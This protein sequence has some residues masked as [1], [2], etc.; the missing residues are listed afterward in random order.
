MRYFFLLMIVVLFGCHQPE[1]KVI[2]KKTPVPTFKTSDSLSRIQKKYREESIADSLHLDSMLSAALLYAYKNKAR[3]NF[4]KNLPW[5]SDYDANAAILLNYGHLFSSYKKH[6][7]ITRHLWA[8]VTCI[9]VFEYENSKFVKINSQYKEG[10]DFVRYQIKDVNGD[11]QKDFLTHW[12]PTS[13]CCRR[14]VY[15]VFLYL[16]KRQAFTGQYEFINPTYSP[17]KKI[18]RGVNY[19]HPGEVPLYKYKWNGLNIDTIEYIYPADTLK[20]KFYLVHRHSEQNDSQKRKTLATVPKEYLK[21]D[22]YDWFID[23]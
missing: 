12:Y 10:W 7:I 15:D 13:G 3:P 11:G 1:K 9:D 22:G 19:G 16:K 4:K 14:N 2:V 20:K 17:A 18:I 23:Y 6:L 8:S 21:I 5:W